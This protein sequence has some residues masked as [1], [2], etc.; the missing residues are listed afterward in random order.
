MFCL[1][2]S[3]AIIEN[4]PNQSFS[5]DDD[6]LS[7]MIETLKKAEDENKKLEE[8]R[9]ASFEKGVQQASVSS[10]GTFSFPAN[11]T[12]TNRNE[13]YPYCFH[14]SLQGQNKSTG[15][16]T[17]T[18]I[19]HASVDYFDILN[20]KESTSIGFTASYEDKEVQKLDAEAAG[21]AELISYGDKGKAALTISLATDVNDVYN[22]GQLVMMR[23]TFASNVHF[24]LYAYGYLV[25]DVETVPL[26]TSEVFAGK[27][28]NTGF[29]MSA[30][31]EESI[32]GIP[33][34]SA[35]ASIELSLRTVKNDLHK[36]RLLG[37]ADAFIR[38]PISTFHFPYTYISDSI[39][40]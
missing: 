2:S 29:N 34:T 4:H 20:P 37:K 8:E 17:K 11:C 24:N 16:T 26:Q 23:D 22:P 21:Q 39:S 15:D 6:T 35:G 5:F 13:S 1:T 40:V 12:P 19:V 14:G 10:N 3:V 38:T 31:Y 9:V 25:M 30:S 7:D 33:F 18:T 32:P 28:Y 27:S 36:W